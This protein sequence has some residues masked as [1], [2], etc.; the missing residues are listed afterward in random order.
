MKCFGVTIVLQRL[1]VQ[2]VRYPGGEDYSTI[3]ESGYLQRLGLGRG[4]PAAGLRLG[5]HYKVRALAA[6]VSLVHFFNAV[7]HHVSCPRGW[8]DVTS[9]LYKS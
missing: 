3:T 2:Y 6:A 5:T 8:S 1:Q 4:L 7:P 9:L